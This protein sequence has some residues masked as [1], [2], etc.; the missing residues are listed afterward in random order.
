M[1]R[2]GGCNGET[3]AGRKGSESR[4]AE[5]GEGGGGRGA[6]TIKWMGVES[7]MGKREDALHGVFGGSRCSRRSFESSERDNAC[8]IR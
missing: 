2:A 6:I 5:G 7:K 8:T 1:G 4:R 3:G